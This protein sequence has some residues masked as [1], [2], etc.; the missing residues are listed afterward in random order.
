MGRKKQLL[1]TKGSSSLSSSFFF[2]FKKPKL[3]EDMIPSITQ[4]EHKGILFGGERERPGGVP[5]N[6][7]LGTICESYA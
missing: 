4:K 3:F 7:Y 6:G 5:Q 1:E 2:F